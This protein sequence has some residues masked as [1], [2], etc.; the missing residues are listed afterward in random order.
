MVG[1]FCC[2]FLPLEDVKAVDE[3]KKVSVGEIT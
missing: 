2:Y 1:N 3:L